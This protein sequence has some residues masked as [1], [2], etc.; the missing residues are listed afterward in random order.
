MGAGE[1]GLKVLL[2]GRA[3]E[4]LT[5]WSEH[6][7]TVLRPG[8][9]RRQFDLDAPEPATGEYECTPSQTAADRLLIRLAASAPI[10][11]LFA[12]AWVL[13]DRM[14]DSADSGERLFRHLRRKN[15]DINAWFV[16]TPDS[17]DYA[18]LR[19]EGYRRIIGYGTL[20]WKLLMLNC[21]HLISSHADGAVLHP[22]VLRTVMPA[23]HVEVH[24]PAA[25]RDQGR[26]RQLSESARRS[27]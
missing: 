15:R 26:H 20:R 5:E 17:P 24:L 11:R 7:V 23:P 18:R 25:R 14:E 9:I 12:D 16:V 21:K 6:T 4:P 27:T 10:R 2:D 13:M 3:V 22:V 19:K 1:R 8:A